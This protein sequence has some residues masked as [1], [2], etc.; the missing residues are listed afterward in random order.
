MTGIGLG[1]GK[2]SGLCIGLGLGL[3]LGLGLGLIFRCSLQIAYVIY[4]YCVDGAEY[5]SHL[6]KNVQ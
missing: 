1:I 2:G 5:N 4:R 6:G 3:E